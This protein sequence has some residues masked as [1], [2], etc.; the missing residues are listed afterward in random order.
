MDATYRGT[1]TLNDGRTVET[2]GTIM[3]CAD[4]SEDILRENGGQIEIRIDEIR[5][6]GK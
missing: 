5:E 3:E 4:W 2:T 6:G 1:A